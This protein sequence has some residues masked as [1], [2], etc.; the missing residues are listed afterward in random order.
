MY[1]T[2][3]KMKLPVSFIFLVTFIF[4]ACSDDASTTEI[5]EAETFSD[6][7]YATISSAQTMDIQI[8][9]GEGPFPTV[10]YVHGGGFFTGDKSAGN[11][12][13]DALVENN[14]VAVSINYRLSGE[15]IFP[16]AVHDCK[17]AV[18]Y[19]RANA[20]KYRI[21]TDKI[22]SWGDSAGGN[23]ASMLGTSSGDSFTEDLTLGNESFSSKV[24]ATVDWFGPINFSTMES[25][26]DA[27]GLTGFMGAGF[28]TDLEADY[29]GLNKISDDPALVALAN[30]TTY[31]DAD[32]AAFFI[33]VGDADPLVP[34]TQ[35][36]SFYQALLVGLGTDKVSFELIEGAGHGGSEF[37]DPVNLEKVIA[38]FDTYLK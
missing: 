37:D 19:L 10:I 5:M 3:E 20:A 25:E 16:A 15:A 22:G 28:N 38:F 13:T 26:A 34:Y 14:Y 27:L 30:P 17:A 32:D 9:A 18:R 4:S 33:Q 36:E 21:D 23:L 1:K 7:A 35:S 8:P 6:V 24:Q 31:I 12:Y 29:M 2:I 11:T